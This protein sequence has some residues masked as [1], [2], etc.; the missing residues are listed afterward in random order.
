MS[1][2]RLPLF[3]TTERPVA[4]VSA[5]RQVLPGRAIIVADTGADVSALT[6]A[7]RFVEELGQR[8][9]RLPVVL[10]TFTEG[11]PAA[12]GRDFERFAG[13]SSVCTLGAAQAAERLP[14]V[15]GD[16]L[17]VLVGQPALIAAHGWLSVLLATEAPLLRWAPGLRALRGGVSLELSGEGLGVATALARELAA[18]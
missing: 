11:A 12:A 4:P 17:W 14:A 7:A 9:R 2:R 16:D 1:G 10:C 3:S 15:A 8:G 6:W 5:A 13:A 18:G